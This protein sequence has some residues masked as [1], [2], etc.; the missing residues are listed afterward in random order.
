[1]LRTRPPTDATDAEGGRGSRGR[2]AHTQRGMHCLKCRQLQMQT[3]S[4]NGLR[5][6]PITHVNQPPVP[7][8]PIAYSTAVETLA[9]KQVHTQEFG[10]GRD[11]CAKSNLEAS[12]LDCCGV[13]SAMRNPTEK[14]QKAHPP[15]R[16]NNTSQRQQHG[17]NLACTRTRACIKRRAAQLRRKQTGWQG[18]QTAAQAEHQ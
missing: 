7:T 12:L 9:L 8:K 13:G 11:S 18:S 17:I 1:M 3:V 14:S 16:N 2:N 6:T 15:P 5:C 4:Y 10:E